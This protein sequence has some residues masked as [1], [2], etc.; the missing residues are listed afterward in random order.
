VVFLSFHLLRRVVCFLWLGPIRG[1]DAFALSHSRGRGDIRGRG[2]ARGE[3]R[4]RPSENGGSVGGDGNSGVGIDGRESEWGGIRD[5]GGR[6]GW[7]FIRLLP[8]LLLPHL[9][10]K[11][12][13]LC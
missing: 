11:F 9:T 10:L 2:I 4:E 12:T 8:P 1:R 3:G 5:G 7:K 13:H 6:G